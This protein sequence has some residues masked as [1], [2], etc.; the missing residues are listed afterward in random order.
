MAYDFSELKTA[1]ERAREWLAGEYR[2]LRTGR[3]NPQFVDGVSVESY[4]ARVPLNQVA[5]VGVEDARTLR[6]TPFD[7]SQV[8]EIEKALANADLG[9]GVSA[10]ERG[11]RVTFPELTAERRETLLRLAKS[12]L[13]EARKSVRSARDETWSDIQRKTR[14]GELSE[15]DKFALKEEMEQMVKDAN[16]ALGALYENKE[17]E[18]HE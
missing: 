13:E 10:D 14:E 7:P 18:M 9:V 17:R 4:G 11:V 1:M 6:I 8:K 5:N 12:K 15:D 16:E 2:S 3:A